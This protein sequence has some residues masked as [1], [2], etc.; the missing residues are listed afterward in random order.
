MVKE[1]VRYATKCKNKPTTTISSDD[2]K[3][4]IGV[5]LISGYHKLPAETQYWSNDEDLGL[6][7]V[8][9]AMSRSRFQEIKGI[10]H[11]CNNNETEN[12]KNDRGFKVRKLIAAA[13]K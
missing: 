4:F 12:N 10:L 11:F 7:I 3:L 5:L 8:K 1:S 13:Q 6:Q 2:I 9:N